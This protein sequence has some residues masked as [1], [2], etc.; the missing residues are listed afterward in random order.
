MKLQERIA[1]AWRVL[2]CQPD[3][4]MAHA[5]AELPPANGDEMQAAMNR[6]LRELVLVF[7]SQRHSGFSAGYAVAALEKLLR[8]KPLRPLTGEPN[9]WNEVMDGVYQNRRC[10]RVFKEAG[11]FD[12]Q[13]YDIEGRIFREPNGLCYT[14]S[15]S[16]VPITFPYTPT[17]EFVDRA[18]EVDAALGSE[19]CPTST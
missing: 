18:Q 6:D 11:R 19:R 12:G 2:R 9:E 14:N 10:S 4:L 7:A 17:T 5:E 13:A 1:L 8:F 16:H 15:D 3:N